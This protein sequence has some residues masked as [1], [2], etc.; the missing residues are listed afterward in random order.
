MDANQ[1]VAATGML[2]PWRDD[3]V[4]PALPLAEWQDTAATLHMWMQVVGKVRMGLTPK[5]NHWW[6]VPLY[7]TTRG[8]TTS[9]VPYQTF[10]FALDFDFLDHQL[11]L[12]T[13]LGQSRAIALAPLAVADFYTATMDALH[14]LGISISIW[15]MPQEVPN[16]IPFDR[17]YIHA[18]YDPEYAQRFWRILVQTD[19]VFSAFRSRFIGKVSP[20]HFFWGSFDMAVTR[21]S[22][23]P[24]PRH[25]S[26]PGM[27]DYITQEAYSHEVSS[28]G[29]WPG[30]EGIEPAF[31]SY[32]Y[33]EPKGYPDY[34]IAPAGATYND[35]LGEFL[36]PYEIVRTASDPTATLL[37]FLQSSYEAAAN[38]MNWDRPTMERP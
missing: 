36:L 16:P 23:R 4:W 10:T 26:I 14:A 37:E 25:P 33:P 13:S 1:Q 38:L 27:A 5:T 35:Q 12:T 22:G 20:V 18:A 9:P 30:G 2:P 19:K 17:D 34:P 21:F 32:A 6:H 11:K 31:Y 24:A 3:E 29:F 8:L 28:A 15:T 7:V